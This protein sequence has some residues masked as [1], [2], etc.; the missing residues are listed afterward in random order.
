MHNYY[1]VFSSKDETVI[2]FGNAV[3]CATALNIKP[4]TFYYYISR[5]KRE[6]TARRRYYIVKEANDSLDE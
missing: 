2:T 6:P 4:E 1:T 3:K 5:Q